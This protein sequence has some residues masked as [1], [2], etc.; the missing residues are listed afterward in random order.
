MEK[1][2]GRDTPSV[3]LSFR[4]KATLQPHF[5]RVYFLIGVMGAKRGIHVCQYS[6]IYRCACCV[7]IFISHSRF[8]NRNNSLPASLGFVL[9]G[10]LL[11]FCHRPFYRHAVMTDNGKSATET[12]MR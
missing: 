2:C 9:L 1:F 12:W 11:D 8:P 4:S 5:S 10:R 3:E 6:R 7:D